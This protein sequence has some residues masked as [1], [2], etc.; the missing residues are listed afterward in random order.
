MYFD[1]KKHETA[2]IPRRSTKTILFIFLLLFY[3][4]FLLSLFTFILFYFIHLI[5]IFGLKSMHDYL[6][7]DCSENVQHV[8]RTLDVGCFPLCFVFGS[9]KERYK[10]AFSLL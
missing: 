1:H 8:T 3:C 5:Y 7:L 2:A 4:T 6:T 9:E 10:L